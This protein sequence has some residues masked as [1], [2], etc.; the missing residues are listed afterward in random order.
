VKEPRGL[1]PN[2]VS[3]WFPQFWLY[4]K[5]LNQFLM[6]QGCH[7]QLFGDYS[8]LGLRSYSLTNPSSG[9]LQLS[10]SNLNFD[11]DR[12]LSARGGDTNVSATMTPKEE[13]IIT[14]I[15]P[16]ARG[17]GGFKVARN[18]IHDERS[19]NVTY[20]VRYSSYDGAH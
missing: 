8:S 2:F 13:F 17:K 1:R 18:V 6:Q 4:L 5:V 9:V 15:P 16:V 20:I 3:W 11:T 7:S 19:R 10:H 12:F 14:I